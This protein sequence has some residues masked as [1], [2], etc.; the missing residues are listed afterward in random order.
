MLRTS[1]KSSVETFALEKFMQKK[2]ESVALTRCNFM[3]RL[4]NIQR[5]LQKY[6]RQIN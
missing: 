2:L 3:S 6:D 1:V 4:T 5:I